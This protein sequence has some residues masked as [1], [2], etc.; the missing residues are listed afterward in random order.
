VESWDISPMGLAA[1][2]RSNANS[3]ASGLKLF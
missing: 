1:F 3:T 2:S